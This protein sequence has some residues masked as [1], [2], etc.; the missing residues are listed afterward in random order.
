MN[1]VSSIATSGISTAQ[2]VGVL[3]EAGDIGREMARPVTAIFD[4]LGRRSSQPWPL[5]VVRPFTAA[6]TDR[7][8][9]WNV[10]HRT[11]GRS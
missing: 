9:Q 6:A 4:D 2:V 10:V 3:K 11:H 8:L 7:Y 1:S 5:G